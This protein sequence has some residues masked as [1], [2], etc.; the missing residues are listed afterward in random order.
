VTG[1]VVG[2]AVVLVVGGEVVVGAVGGAG[3]RD[4]SA[5]GDAIGAVV[6]D[7]VTR[8]VVDVV[9]SAVVAG[10]ET[11]TAVGGV[12]VG[13]VGERVVAGSVV[14]ELAIPRLPPELVIGPAISITHTARTPTTA[15]A[16]PNKSA[17]QPGFASATLTSRAR[18]PRTA[19]R[20]SCF[21][22]GVSL[23]MTPA[24]KASLEASS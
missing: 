18:G 16:P 22:K 2:G 10:D 7:G 14:P 5:V 21:T 20:C 8:T 9:I 1:V 15:A 17:R 4:G 11:P 24:S 6:G 13:A 23:V 3:T 19:R 12:V